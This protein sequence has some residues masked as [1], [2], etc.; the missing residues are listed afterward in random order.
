MFPALPYM[1]RV[2]TKDDVLPLQTPIVTPDGRIVDSVP[3]SKGQIISL[4][5]IAI[6]R[7]NAIWEDPMN[8]RPDRWLSPLPHPELTPRGWGNTL[9]FSEGPRNCVGYRLGNYSQCQSLSYLSDCPLVNRHLPI[10]SNSVDLHQ[11]PE[12]DRYR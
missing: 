8:F 5:I 10:Q 12:D 11:R 1:E 9:T 2:A 3:I 4:P 6:N 7:M